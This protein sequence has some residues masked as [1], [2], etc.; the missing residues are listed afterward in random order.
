MARKGER[1]RT[2]SS[3][4]RF[5]TRSVLLDACVLIRLHKCEALGLLER[6]IAFLVA[7]HA[8]GEFAAGGPSARAA[9]DRL[10]VERRYI[11]S[12]SKEWGHFSRIRS[13]F[14]TVDLGEDESIAVALAEADRGNQVPIVT[15]DEEATKK[16]RSL[17]LAAMSFLERWLGCLRAV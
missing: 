7:A 16:A 12:G 1:P 2:E 10:R 15:Y 11:T 3:R 6:T 9:L 17:G 14:S 8:Y 4:S 5:P 13:E